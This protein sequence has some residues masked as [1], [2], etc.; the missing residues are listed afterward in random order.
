MV[1]LKNIIRSFLP[2][3]IKPYKILA[4]ILQGAYIVTSWHDYPAAILG[5]T[6]RSLLKWFSKNIT[7][8]ET[9]LDVG[10]HYG[11]TSVALCKFVGEHGRVIAFEPMLSTAG[12]LAQTRQI[13]RFS[14]LIILPFG[15]AAEYSMNLL[16]LPVVRGMV[17]STMDKDQASWFETIIV[18]KLDQVWSSICGINPHI[19]GVK[20]DVQGMEIEVLKGM[21]DILKT[22]RPKLVVEVH[23]GVD[24]QE[25]LRVIES[26]G[27]SLEAVP[28]EPLEG[29]EKAQFI[30]D[31]SYSF[32]T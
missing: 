32:T 19:D 25:L 11:Y 14:Q 1:G 17:D 26:F 30:D 9:W 8:G 21:K 29:E 18:I 13:N 22:N 3:S 12:Y 2:H 10:A 4:G 24:R 20:V 28:I 27:Y 5:Y 15:L 31:R 7:P 6:E 23:R 16:N